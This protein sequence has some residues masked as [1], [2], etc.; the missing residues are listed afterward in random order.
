MT[1]KKILSP[2]DVATIRNKGTTVNSS[3]LVSS[4]PDLAAILSKSTTSPLHTSLGNDK[5]NYFTTNGGKVQAISEQT[6]Q[7]TRDNESILSLFPE[8]EIV[9]Q[10]IVSSILS[11]KDMQGEKLNYV[12]EDHDIPSVISSEVATYIT[13]EMR[14]YYGLEKDLYR[15]L[16]EYKFKKGAHIRVVLPESILDS[17][18]NNRN[19]V[20][21]AMEA[22]SNSK[23][24]LFNPDGSVVGLGILGDPH[25]KQYENSN[26]YLSPALENFSKGYKVDNNTK[27]GLIASLKEKKF[28]IG[29]EV[30]TLKAVDY[31]LSKHIEITDNFEIVKIPHLTNKTMEE[32]IAEKLYARHNNYLNLNQKE[33]IEA[34][35][36]R[37]PSN[38]TVESIKDNIAVGK[39]TPEQ[40]ASMTYR[41]DTPISEPYVTIPSSKTRKRKDIG[42]PLYFEVDTSA[43][44]PV[45]MPGNPTKRV[46]ILMLVEANGTP[47]NANTYS[48]EEMM[49]SLNLAS[50]QNNSLA[51]GLLERA[52]HNLV[53]NDEEIVLDNVAEIFGSLL[54]DQFN[55]MFVNGVFGHDVELGSTNMFYLTMLTRVWANRMTRI[56]FIPNEF[57]T[58]FAFKYF[59]NGVGKSYLDEIKTLTSMRAILMF[60]RV[61]GMAKNSIDTTRVN[62]I[63]DPR[64]ADPRKTIEIGMHDVM[65]LRQSYFPLGINSPVDLVQWITRVGLVFTFE[66][67]PG[68]PNTKFE[69]DNAKINHDLPDMD[70]DDDL[71]RRTYMSFGLAPEI[72]EEAFSANFAT[73]FAHQNA[74]QSRRI[75]IHQGIFREHL[76]DHAIKTSKADAVIRGNIRSIVEKNLSALEGRLDEEDKELLLND[77]QTFINEYIQRLIEAIEA[78]LPEPNFNALSNQRENYETYKAFVTDLVRHYLSDEVLYGEE[79]DNV[80]PEMINQLGVIYVNKLMRDYV[81]ANNILPEVAKLFQKSNEGQASLDIAKELDGHIANVALCALEL[82]KRLT[83]VKTAVSTD[84]DNLNVDPDN[85]DSTGFSD[86]GDSYDGGDDSGADDDMSL[87][88]DMSIGEGEDFTMP[89]L[90]TEGMGEETT[91]E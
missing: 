17:L 42:R 44:V 53:A 54:S 71:R 31:D 30:R 38:I 47:V 75:Q 28:K 10:I 74:I 24:G 19:N 58:Y 59:D 6:I 20:N 9:E 3:S 80:T 86:G 73:V 56:V 51:T 49:N 27:H 88:G 26:K 63:I 61:M 33:T 52:R 34:T 66:G 39:L 8:L 15:I 45:C 18:I 12:I 67:H 37:G 43:I 1:D 25:K 60:A 23:Y 36:R 89:E 11:P 13:S 72:V 69:F 90:E 70:M 65:K 16:S 76:T 81:S 68:L 46:G 48:R 83:P 2:L 57:Y 55:E 21:L 78:K 50:S 87:D 85:V 40:F 29:E 64:D 41:T 7:R 35:G 77:K 79:F 32:R 91:K 84:M 14:D 22:I 82:V 62:M 4:R 5:S